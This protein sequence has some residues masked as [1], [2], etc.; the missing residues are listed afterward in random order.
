MNHEVINHSTKKSLSMIK[1]L[2]I[3]LTFLICQSTFS[4]SFK[5]G[6]AVQVLWKN[7]WYPGKIEEVKGDKF[8]ISYDGYDASWNETVEIDRL[9][10]GTA[11]A[12]TNTTNT[13]NTTTTTTQTKWSFAGVETIHDLDQSPDG[14]Y[15]L[16]TSAYSKLYILNA[17]DLTLVTEIKVSKN[18]PFTGT[19]SQDGEYIATG[20]YNGKTI[21][22]KRKE[23]TEFVEVDSLSGYSSIF[24]MRFSP[25]NND[26][27][28]SG[29]PK[30]D[31]TDTQID[32]WNIKTGKIKYNLLTSTNAEKSISD[33]EWSNDGSKIAVAI[34]NKKKGIE[35]Y[36][37]TGKLSYRIEHTH[38]VTTAAF[39]PDGGIL[40]T[41]GIDGKITL[42]NLTT[43]KQIWSKTWRDGSVQ[44]LSD[45]AFAPNGLTIAACGQGSGAPVKLYNLASGTVKQEL[46][47]TNP[48]GNQVFYSADS[49][50]I[51]VAY[52]TY[53]DAFKVSMVQKFL[54]PE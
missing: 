53:G 34:S 48:V 19:W 23:G 32:V 1:Y 26:L 54:L 47:T 29:S 5:K 31:Y 13:T 17:S 14:K 45:L 27:M 2:F 12:T 4:Q 28:V 10:V 7:N 18:V 20:D 16:A 42:W 8:L 43:K 39:S 40:A 25:V 9:K 35:I 44:Y 46:G 37:S 30:A 52:T 36:D 50:N 22:Y 15:I 21:I 38:D 6:D 51:F 24:K 11:S 41:G 3:L 49:K 33:I